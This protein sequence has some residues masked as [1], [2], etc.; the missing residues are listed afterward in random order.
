M[1]RSSRLHARRLTLCDTGYAATHSPTHPPMLQHILELHLHTQPSSEK[2]YEDWR[3]NTTTT[4]F[5][6][7]NSYLLSKFVKLELASAAFGLCEVRYRAKRSHNGD[8]SSIN[9][10]TVMVF[11]TDFPCRVRVSL[12]NWTAGLL[13]GAG[14]ISK[15][16]MRPSKVP[17][18]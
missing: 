10:T 7:S 5:F 9:R 3:S 4:G 11:I 17:N 14:R 18:T 2:T 15:V 13:M 6:T 1:H 8:S 16:A 12:I